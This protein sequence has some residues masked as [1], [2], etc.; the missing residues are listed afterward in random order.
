MKRTPLII[1]FIL[2]IT[3]C[4]ST[5][6]WVLQFIQPQPRPMVAPPESVQ[7]APPLSAAAVLFG[8]SVGVHSADNYILTGIILAARPAD[9]IAIL[10]S[11]GQAAHPYRLHAQIASGV[12][13]VEIQP[14]HVLLS[15]HGVLKQL[16][17]AAVQGLMVTSNPSISKTTK[18]R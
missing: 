14:D 17:L 8:G 12:E 16:N 2:F 15:E 13:L 3:V 6:Y 4:A 11:T 7:L 10:A 1:S 9:R 18:V 5:A